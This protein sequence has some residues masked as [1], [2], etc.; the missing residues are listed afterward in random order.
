M[1]LQTKNLI[2]FLTHNFNEVFL[3]TLRNI[4]DKDKNKI[5]ILFDKTAD[6]KK[7]YELLSETDKD[8][9]NSFEL[10]EGTRTKMPY[11]PKGGHS[12]YYHFLKK[13][14]KYIYDSDFIWVFE[15][16]VFFSG[17]INDLI[18]AHNHM[19]HDVIVSEYGGRIP[20]WRW[21]RDGISNNLKELYDYTGVLACVCRFSSTFM[22]LFVD[23]I[24]IEFDGYLEISIPLICK[25]H[26]LTICQFIPNYIGK[27]YHV[28]NPF[29]RVVKEKIIKKNNMVAFFK[30]K[31]YHP[32]KL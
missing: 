15:N 32:I 22:K 13:N 10:I 1:K 21:E 24:G 31:L 20:K 5:V 11:D 29:T 4:N 19:K 2:L 26:N 9:L 16:D 6:M 25:K 28:G 30:N 27:S 3:M 17:D 14:P 8:M 18:S 7:H 12:M 23:K